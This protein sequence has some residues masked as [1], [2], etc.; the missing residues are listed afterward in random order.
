MAPVEQFKVALAQLNSTIGDTAANLDRAM[1]YIAKAGEAGADLVMFPELY[2]QGYRVDEKT[3]ETAEPINGPS[4]EKLIQA[5]KKHG[6]YIIMGM[7]RSEDH[8]PYLVYNS[9][10]FVGPEGLVGDG[11]YDKIHLGTFHPYIE[12]VYFAPGRRV[13]VFDTKF[14]RV[15]LQICYDACFPELTRAYALNGSVVNLVIS[16]GPSVAVDSWRILLQCRSMENL[17]PSVYCNVV[18]WQK[19][20]SFFG[21]SKIVS[22]G[23]QVTKEA[24]IDEEDFIVG[25]VNIA[26]GILMRRQWLYF[27]ERRP[28]LYGALTAPL[29]ELA[30][31]PPTV[32]QNGVVRAVAGLI[33]KS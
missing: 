22:A 8:F 33:A 2:L 19:D 26:Q 16:A 5:A 24:K 15:S 9:S 4:V 28:D 13:P 23:G 10:C 3:A 27:R 11:Y 30:V 14:G 7:A 31:A 12:G 17:M 21:G 18:G 25:T 1:E 29:D 6:L 20:F 32:S